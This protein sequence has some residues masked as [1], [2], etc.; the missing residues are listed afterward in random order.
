MRGHLPHLTSIALGALVLAAVPI[1]IARA[2]DPARKPATAPVPYVVKSAASLAD[3][4]K[5]LQGKGGHSAELVKPGA[6]ALEVVWR[7][8]EDHE[9]K[10]LEVHDGKDHVFF[11][12]EGQAA[13]TLG[14]E[15][16]SPREISSGEWRGARAK[17]SQII[18]AKKGDLI[19]IP[20]GTVHGRSAK[21]SRFTML[22]LSFWPGGAPGVTTTAAAAAPASPAPKK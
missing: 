17:G 5:T 7:H 11:V 9:G 21:G 16:E 2:A 15:L 10:E 19:F 13:L 6:V 14:G 4:E 1:R 8:E 22:Q 3:L 12:T 18:E 20:H